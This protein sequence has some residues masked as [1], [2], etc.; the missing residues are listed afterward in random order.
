MLF[1]VMKRRKV[2]FVLKKL[3][4]FEISGSHGGE[5]EVYSLLGCRAV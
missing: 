1:V 3:I 2:K 5:Y 4:L